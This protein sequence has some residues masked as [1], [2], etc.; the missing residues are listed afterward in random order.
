M[1]PLWREH[2]RSLWYSHPSDLK[3]LAH[4][5]ELLR[6]R[7]DCWCRCVLMSGNENP[8]ILEF[9]FLPSGRL[10]LPYL[11]IHNSHPV[12]CIPEKFLCNHP[13]SLLNHSDGRVRNKP[14]SFLGLPGNNSCCCKWY[15]KNVKKFQ[16]KNV[17]IY[18]FLYVLFFD[19]LM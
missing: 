5:W 15:Y 7:A 17:G 3:V 14:C 10:F 4:L 19:T 16:H 6:L 12:G 11:G 1:L 13:V 8:L 18:A 2:I 9:F